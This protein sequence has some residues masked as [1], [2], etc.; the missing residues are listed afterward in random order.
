M[1]V[2]ID[3]DVGAANESAYIETYRNML[4]QLPKLNVTSS[5]LVARS[6]KPTT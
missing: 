4:F 3:L 2:S 6:I 1:I 5:I